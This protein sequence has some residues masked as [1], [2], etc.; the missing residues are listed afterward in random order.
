MEISPWNFNYAS[1]VYTWSKEIQVQFLFSP[2]LSSTTVAVLG[3]TFWSM[4]HFQLIFATSVQSVLVHLFLHVE[5]QLFQHHW[6]KRLS[7]LHCIAFPLLTKIS[8]LYLWGS[9]SGFPSPFHWS[10]SILLPKPHSPYSCSFIVCLE[11]KYY[12][13]ILQLCSH[14]IL[15]WLFWVFCLFLWI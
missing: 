5:V 3:F 1:L 7:F 4:I 15:C 9:I 12:L 8:W 10:L 6:L 11:V 14:S 2:L 13:S